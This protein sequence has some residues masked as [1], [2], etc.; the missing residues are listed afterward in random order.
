MTATLLICTILV[1]VE[2]NETWS[3]LKRADGG[4]SMYDSGGELKA[5]TIRDIIGSQH[6]F[7]ANKE[8]LA[9]FDIEGK[10]IRGLEGFQKYSFTTEENPLT[11][12]QFSQNP[13]TFQNVEKPQLARN[14]G[15]TKSNPTVPPVKILPPRSPRSTLPT[16]SPQTNPLTP[17]VQRSVTTPRGHTT[18]FNDKGQNMGRSYSIPSGKTMYFDQNGRNLG[19]SQTLR[20]GPNTQTYYYDRYGR[21]QK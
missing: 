16:T 1:A 13:Q 15:P 14:N 12:S 21:R 19:S 18:Y 7:S 10:F 2:P 17:N 3:V 4:I 11:Y 9:S 5:Y 8:F 20:H 6:L